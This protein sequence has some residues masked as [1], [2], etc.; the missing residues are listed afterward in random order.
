MTSLITMP[1]NRD[2]TDESGEIKQE[3][4]IQTGAMLSLPPISRDDLA[5]FRACLI[6]SS[7]ILLF[8]G[9]GLSAPSGIPTFRGSNTSWRGLSPR[10]IS[11]PYFL[12]E[13]PVL[14]WHHFNHRRSMAVKAKPNA[15]H[16]ALAELA[17]RWGSECLAI[18]QNID[19]LSQRAGHVDGI[20][21]IHGS[22]FETECS[23]PDCDHAEVKYDT[24][25]IVA[26]LAVPD[27]VDISDPRIPLPPTTEAQLPR[28]P[29]CH[30]IMRPSVVLFAEQLYQNAVDEIE[31]WLEE[32]SVD[33]VLVVGTNASVHPAVGYLE[34]AIESGAKIAIVNIAPADYMNT[35]PA[36]KEIL[37][38]KGPESTLKAPSITKTNIDRKDVSA[39]EVPDPREVKATIAKTQYSKPLPKILTLPPEILQKILLQTFPL[40]P[41]KP[42]LLRAPALFRGM[43]ASSARF[44]HF[45]SVRI[46]HTNEF[47]KDDHKKVFAWADGLKV[48]FAGW[49]DASEGMEDNVEFVGESFIEELVKWK[50]ERVDVVEEWIEGVRKV[51]QRG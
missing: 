41:R 7:R 21:N 4:R 2:G 40:K 10:D 35:K 5:S 39:A 50:R 16:F 12:K 14:F 3:L 46:D 38:L 48:A 28:C 20:V 24:D 11:S 31:E 49:G 25:P 37:R 17:S 8:L 9:A 6:S 32:D 22:L 13:N 51:I 19:R 26:G 1:V 27:G 44:E 18:N 29:I 47:Y 34:Q 43:H 15:G 45:A 30:S 33:L 42:L 23:N 36:K